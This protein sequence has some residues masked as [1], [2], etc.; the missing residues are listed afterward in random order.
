MH[1]FEPLVLT[2][3]KEIFAALKN[4][5]ES[6][7][8]KNYWTGRMMDWVMKDPNFKIDLFRFVDVL[9]VLTDKDQVSKHI[10]E[11]LLQKNREIPLLMGTAFKAASFSFARGMASSII[12]KNVCEMA[13]K[14]II[15]ENL[16]S[17]SKQLSKLA[18]QG[19]SFTIDLLGEKTLSNEEAN[20]YLDH[21]TNLIKELPKV[22]DCTSKEPP[23]ISIKVSALCPN[24]KEE[25]PHFFVEQ[26]KSKVIPLLK[27]AHSNNVF[28]NFDVESYQSHEIISL[29]FHQI[30]LEDE[31]SC[32][33][34]LGIVVQAYLKNSKRHLS[35]LIDIAKQRKT[36][37]SIRLVKG[38]YWD[39]EVV[40]AQQ[41]GHECP[42]FLDK[43]KTDQNYEFLSKILLDNSE[44]VRPC[45]ASHNIRS[46]AHAIA[47]AKNKNIPI[48]HY[49]IQMLY[50]MAES[51]RKV[52][53]QR[54]HHVRLYMPIGEM[55][56]GMSYLV[57]RLLENTSQ[58]SFVKKK[59]HDHE[60]E[61]YLLQAP[62][63]EELPQNEKQ[64]K[65]QNEHMLDFT[66]TS[67]RKNFSQALQD[68]KKQFPIKI[69]IIINGDKHVSNQNLSTR[70]PSD[71]T[72]DIAQIDLATQ[73]HASNAVAQSV[74]SFSRLS[75]LDIKERL[76]HL[77]NLAII[78]E[79]DRFK[80]AALICYEVGKT[81]AEADA[82]VAEAID[83]CC[84]Y[85]LC[86][87]TELNPPLIGQ[88][89]GEENNLVYQA[90]GPAL[91][92]A[93]W[94]FP[95]AI[96]CGMSV[97][98]YVCGN[99]IIMKPAEQ[100]CSTAYFLYQS[101]IEAGFLSDSVQFLPSK[102]EE[103]GPYLVAHPEIANICFTGS[104]EVGHQIERLA[105][106]VSHEQVQMK[107]VIAEMG[108]KN[109]III[110]DDADLDEAVF[111]VLKS[112]FSYAGQ[113]CS[114][115]SKVIVLNSIADQFIDRIK[116]ATQSIIVDSAL[117][118][119]TFMGPVI[120]EEA[121]MRLKE[122]IKML[123]EDEKIK[124]IYI[125]ENKN[126]GFFVP[127]AI[128]LVEDQNHWLMQEE[129]FGPIL[130]LYKAKDLE[131]ALMVANNTRFALTG[132]LFSRSPQNIAKAKSLFRVGNLYINQ[133]C[134]GA[135][136]NRQP[137]GGFKMSG[138]GI[139]AGGPH[140][141]LNFV[142]AKVISENT[143]RRG[144]T[145]QISV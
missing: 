44:F 54:G 77:N 114:A 142:D 87:D 104:M 101:M 10:E 106:N 73:E 28:I 132:A 100:S 26:L 32:W 8:D 130:A 13:Q 90:R 88:V 95:L 84:Y 136:V 105:H 123:R 25:A 46:L 96:L 72:I 17:A 61:E 12:K 5:K 124:S 67:V 140:Y 143:M 52:F 82:D 49:E 109:A 97:A 19:F 68:I 56:P 31:F 50:G 128:F 48:N 75:T 14:F 135:M 3:G 36:P 1:Q 60:N 20:F 58:M 81:W 145:P 71:T 107:R 127:P 63:G 78:L 139:K 34:H 80:L 39:Y 11:Y 133:K 6:L 33:P 85:A 117:L 45:F 18:K 51:E 92:I 9:P 93:P 79:R 47:Y 126:L 27:L 70:C 138:T 144:F 134:T 86:A 24:L 99:P 37:F 15:G 121:Q 116:A 38:A 115:A 137:F 83:F 74:K 89:G 64:N 2:E 23:N 69:P 119:M 16:A 21:Y 110:D 30:A 122:K 113:K 41:F 141:L 103:I 35:E 65:F 131:H 59:Q 118:P 112:A 125:G 120:D 98:A 7:F 22:L 43:F 94:N 91:I 102:G 62:N 111:G 29:L 76:R 66:Q 42:V 57:R 55:L 40:K 4:E 53:Q 108:G 129:L